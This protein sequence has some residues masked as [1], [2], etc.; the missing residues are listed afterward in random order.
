MPPAS[1]IP[2]SRDARKAGLPAPF[3]LRLGLS[4]ATAAI[5]PWASEMDLDVISVM[6]S[7]PTVTA[8][9]SGFSRSPLH[10]SQ[11]L[12]AMYFA[13]MSAR[14]FSDSLSLYRRARLLTTPSNSVAH[15]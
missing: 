1:G 13:S 4:P 10:E 11:G 6:L 15:S 2:P 14:T 3:V 9:A 7:P 8:S 5:H 12:E